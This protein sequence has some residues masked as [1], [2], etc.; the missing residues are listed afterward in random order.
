MRVCPSISRCVIINLFGAKKEK[1]IISPVISSPVITRLVQ[2]PPAGSEV[3]MADRAV[4]L[5]Q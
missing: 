2:Y 5:S 4:G 1:M 3:F